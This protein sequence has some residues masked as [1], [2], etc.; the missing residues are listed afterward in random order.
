MGGVGG[1]ARC[2][3]WEALDRGRIWSKTP[4]DDTRVMI[5]ITNLHGLKARLVTQQPLNL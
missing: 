5:R 2:A 1:V 4:I 3:S